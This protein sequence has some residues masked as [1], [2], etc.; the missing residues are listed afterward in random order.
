GE[1]IN[2]PVTLH[3]QGE[4]DITNFACTWYGAGWDSPLWLE[5]DIS[6][7]K[8]ESKEFTIPVT[9]PD[10]GKENRLVFRANVDGATPSSELNQDNN[11]M[12]ITVQP[13]G[14]DIAVKLAPRQPFWEIPLDIGYV[15]PSVTL[16]GDIKME[17]RVLFEADGYFEANGIKKE[18]FK[19]IKASGQEAMENSF[20][21]KVTQPGIYRVKGCIPALDEHGNP[22]MFEVDFEQYPDINPANNCDEIDIEV[23]MGA[24][25]GG[26]VQPIVNPPNYDGDD[27]IRPV[28]TG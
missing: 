28:I 7:A 25:K 12:I 20:S 10:F 13:D 15:H 1:M 8:G 19:F 21:F 3:N 22:I 16:E 14:L 24:P 18:D 23:R 9:V 17:H 2:I 26:G 27:T 4:E 6:L 5:G 11:I